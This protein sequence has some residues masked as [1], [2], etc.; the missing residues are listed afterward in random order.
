[1]VAG[2]PVFHWLYFFLR[3]NF[4]WWIAL[5]KNWQGHYISVGHFGFQTKVS[6]DV[7]LPGT[8]HFTDLGVDLTY[9]YLANY[10][11]IYEFKTSYIREQ[12][13]LYATQPTGAVNV[14]QQ[15]GFLGLNAAYTYLQTYGFTFGY[16]HIYGNTDAILYSNSPTNRPNSEY[17]TFQFDYVP[18]GKVATTGLQSYLNLRFTAQYIA[19]TMMD[20]G[21]NNYDGNGRN[22]SDNNT[23]YFNTGLD[24]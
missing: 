13:S 18:F 8:D 17:F 11:H 24:F 5:Q 12:Q 21:V 19:Y 1:M 3:F 20:G 4:I 9:Q 16:N 10:D 15:L 14:N 23:L 6:P 7:T 22:A 2:F